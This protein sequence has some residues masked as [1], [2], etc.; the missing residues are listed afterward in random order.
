MRKRTCTLLLLLITLA[1]ASLAQADGRAYYEIFPA[2]FYD[3]NADGVGDLNGIEEKIDYLVALG[4]EGIWLMPIHPSPSYH[5]YDVLDYYGVDSTYGTLDDFASLADALHQANMTLLLDLVL[6]HTSSQ[7]PWFLS[8]IE[9]LPIEPC[10]EDT[11]SETPYC[12]AHNPYVAY[13]HFSQESTPGWHTVPQAEGWYYLGHFTHEMPD[14]NL[15]N[16]DLRAEIQSICAFW[17]VQGADGFRLDAVPHYFEENVEENNAFVAWLM[18]SLRAVKPDVYV[19]GEV[20]KDAGSIARYYESGISSIFNYPF[21]GAEGAIVSA[22]RSKKGA[23]LAQKADAWQKTVQSFPNAVDAPFLSNHDNAR[24]AGTLMQKPENLKLAASLYLTLPGSPFLYYGE[25]IG[26]TGSGKDE[27]KRLPMLWDTDASPGYCLPPPNADQVASTLGSVQAQ[28]SSAD[29]L[30][31][32]YQRLLALRKEHSA[33]RSGTLQAID[34]GNS[35]IC[36]YTVTDEN[37]SLLVLHNLGKEPLRVDLFGQTF[38]I[39]PAE[40]IIQPLDRP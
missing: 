6:N 36:A 9:S 26:M 1:A 18:E 28:L 17:L 33:L 27:N 39:D 10:G 13:Y 38:A 5:K 8:A 12:R 20:W 22:I 37:E 16:P 32:H 15:A 24:I 21:S 34:G 3:A 29:S 19:V 11:C 2:S 40:T 7:H 23:S 35:A 14:L 25:E 30:L 4:V 31:A